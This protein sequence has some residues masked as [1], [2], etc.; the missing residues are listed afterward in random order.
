ME[1]GTIEQVDERAAREAREALAEHDGTLDGD[2]GPE[3][4]PEEPE[5]ADTRP[6][7]AAD[8]EPQAEAG[9]LVLEGTGEKL[10]A[11]VGG[12][13]P[14]TSKLTIT[15]GQIEVAGVYSKGDKIVV[16]IE[17][18]VDFVGFKDETDSKT[19]QVVGCARQHKARI[20]G[21]REI[22]REG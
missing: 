11:T 4:P 7:G 15:G 18:T 12:K 10:T 22:S 19:R 1:A 3:E 17:A 16:E 6:G 8:D 21:V 13:A 14:T 2:P 9:Q 5:A 20:T